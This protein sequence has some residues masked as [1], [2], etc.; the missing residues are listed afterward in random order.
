[1]TEGSTVNKQTWQALKIIAKLL[2][3][4]KNKPPIT[5]ISALK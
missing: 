5:S 2:L 1:L 4:L 3:I